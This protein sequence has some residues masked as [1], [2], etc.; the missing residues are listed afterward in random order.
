VE[1]ALNNGKEIYFPTEFLHGLY[2]G[3]H[4]A[5]LD[6]YWNLM[7]TKRRG[8]RGEVNP[9]FPSGNISFLHG[10]SAIGTKFSSAAAEGPQGQKNVYD[11]KSE[12]LKGT[13]YFRFGE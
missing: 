3:G 1:N 10:I 6:D 5:G 7:V 13:L 11:G 2:D 8:V 12:P 4:G 9:P